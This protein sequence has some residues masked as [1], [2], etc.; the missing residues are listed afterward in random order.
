MEKKCIL[1][2]QNFTPIHNRGSEQLYCSKKCRT[3]ALKERFK[4]KN[5]NEIIS[6]YKTRSQNPFDYSH[7][8]S[9]PVPQFT[10]PSFSTAHTPSN[11]SFVADSMEEKYLVGLR[12]VHF[13]WD[14][15]FLDNN[16]L[17]RYGMKFKWH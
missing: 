13:L 3:I 16:D 17:S 1:C 9:A 14:M 8:V 4:E 11:N 15:G 12:C 2:T 5:K 6:D 7:N 10:S